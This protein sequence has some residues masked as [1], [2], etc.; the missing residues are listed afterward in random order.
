LG[1]QFPAFQAHRLAQPQPFFDAAQIGVRAVV[2]QDA[3]NPGAP[4]VALG[5]V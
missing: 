4:D 3:L 2:I 1:K 5:T